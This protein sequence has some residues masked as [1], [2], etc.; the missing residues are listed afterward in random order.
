MRVPAA[1]D[2]GVAA[3]MRDV[4]W[5]GLENGVR[6]DAP[7]TWTIEQPVKL[8]KLKDHPAF[9]AVGSARLLAAIDAVLEAQVYEKPR[10]W[11]A[12]FVAFM[13]GWAL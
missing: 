7:A 11:G 8:Q 2:S 10:R 1:F 13:H 5:R 4:V 3:A 9:N 6:R 12:I